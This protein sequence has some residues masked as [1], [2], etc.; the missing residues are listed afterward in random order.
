MA[1]VDQLLEPGAANR[2]ER[3]LG[4]DEETVQQDQNGNA[5][6]LEDNRHA[7]VSGAAVL[8]GSS[9]TTARQYRRRWRRLRSAAA[10]G[11]RPRPGGRAAPGGRGSRRPRIVA[12]QA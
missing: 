11:A 7:P 5:E 12:M 2:H 9:P 4:R 6:K 8:E 10:R 3:V 1:L